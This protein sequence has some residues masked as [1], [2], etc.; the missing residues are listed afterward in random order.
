MAAGMSRE[1]DPARLTD[2]LGERWALGETSFKF[3]AAC[4]HT[5][6]AADAL[7]RVM[8]EDAL[9]ARGHRARHRARAS[10]GDRRARPGR[11]IRKPCIRPNFRWAPCSAWSPPAAARACSISNAF[12]R[13]AATV[14]FA[15]QSVDGVR[16]GGAGRLSR[17]A[18][19]ARWR[20]KPTTD[21]ARRPR[22]RAQRRSGNTL[23]RAE[24]EAKA[25]GLAAFSKSATPEEMERWFTSF[26]ASARRADA[27]FLR[28][29]VR[30]RLKMLDG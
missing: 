12:L 4:R 15:R 2:R 22:R 17:S 27:E 11:P 10:G 7:L 25:L 18:G 21:A 26:P 24:I 8:Q 19:S 9:E 1:A 6:P 23:S 13:G 5:H 30:R 20:S 14:E 16:S 29:A 3:H 28:R